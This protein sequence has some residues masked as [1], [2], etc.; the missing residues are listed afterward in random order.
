M[1]LIAPFYRGRGQ[2]ASIHQD[3]R[4][5]I[6]SDELWQA[7]KARQEAL[8]GSTVKLRGALKRIGRLPRHLL[9]GLLVCE[10]CGGTFRCVNGHEYG[11]TSYRW[12]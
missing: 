2:T 10:H 4:L 7:L 1:R 6:V 8:K 5:R 12:R 3:P 9:S 11:C